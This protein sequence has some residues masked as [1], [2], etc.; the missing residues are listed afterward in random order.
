MKTKLKWHDLLPVVCFFA[1][2]LALTAMEFLLPKQTQS[3]AENRTLA[4]RPTLTQAASAAS[5]AGQSSGF[6]ARVKQISKLTQQFEKYVS[7]HVP[8]REQLVRTFSA[9]ELAQGKKQVRLAYCLDGGWLFTK[10]TRLN[11]S[12]LEQLTAAL[13]ALQDEAGLPM[14]YCVLP[15]KNAVVYDCDPLYFSD[16]IDTENRAAL[17]SALEGVEGLHVLDGVSALRA[18]TFS[19]RTGLFFKTDFHWNA[20]GAYAVSAELAQQLAEQGLIQPSSIPGDGAFRWNDL[21][22]RGY[23]GDLNKWYSNYFSVYETL[24]L[25]APADPSA[26][27]YYEHLDSAEPTA[28]EAIVASGL[29]KELVDY[30]DVF[31]YNLGYFRV[32]NPNAPEDK[33]VLILKDSYQNATLDYFTQIF[34]EVNVVDPRNYQETEQL[35]QLLSARS[36]DLVLFFYHQNNVSSELIGLLNTR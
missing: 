21:T 5:S 6:D 23:Q 26:L 7:D 14:A 11:A 17:L 28:R 29:D 35:T 8:G 18:K 24:E 3:S 10:S 19:E 15:V 13:Q 9:L 20:R 31:T 30:N 33:A 16:A 2:F 27:R 25:Y 22:G 4:E 12:K 1:F 34:R 32:E 36:I